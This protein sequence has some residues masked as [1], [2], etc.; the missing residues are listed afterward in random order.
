MLG[1]AAIPALGEPREPEPTASP[2]APSGTTASAEAASPEAATPHAAAAAASDGSINVLVFHGE[3]GEQD[4]PVAEATQAIEDLGAQHGFDVESST[5]PDVFS[6]RNL[7]GYRGVVFLS[8]E[9]TELTSGQEGALQAYLENGGGFLGIRDAARA[10]ERSEWFTGLIGTRPV[11]SLPDPEEIVEVTASGNNPPNEIAE[12]LIDGDVNTKWLTFD[13]TAWIVVRLSEPTVVSQYA[14]ASANDAPGRDPRDWT[15]QGSADG[16]SWTDLDTRAGESFTDRFQTRGFEFENGD[17]YEYYRLD[18][19]ANN[20]DGLTQM[21]EFQ[22]FA[23]DGTEEPEP[24]IEEQQA[25]VSVVDSLHPATDGLPLTWERSDRWINWDPNPTGQVHTVAQVQEHTYD[26]GNGANG[27]FHPISWCRDY[28]GGRSFY[29]GM[30][31]TAESYADEN[32][33]AHLLGAIHWTTGMVRADCQATIGSNYSIERL[34]DTNQP[35]ELD[36]IGEPHGLDIAPDGKVFYIGKAACPSGPIPDWNDPDVGLGCGTIHQWDPETEEATLLLTLDVFGN[37]GSG[38]ELVKTEEGLVGITLDPDFQ[39]NGWLYIYWMPYESIDLETRIG[40]RTVSRLT[41]DFDSASID[42]ETREDLLQW[43]TQIHSCCHAGGGMDFDA[44]GNLYIGTGDANSSQGSSGYSGNNWTQDYLGVSFQD[45]RRTSGNT[46]NLNGKILRITPEADGTYSIPDGNLFTGDEE[47]GGLTQPEIYVMGVRNMSTLSVDPD[48]DWLYAAW[49]GPDA[50]APS[51]ELGPAKYESATVVTE[52]GNEGWPFCVGNRQ[53]YRDRS[54]EDASILTGW[55]DCDNPKNESPRNT[56][57]VDLPPIRD[58]MIWYAPQGGGPVYPERG[59]GSGLPTYVED[60]ATYTQP[61]L[62]GGG[63]AIMSGPAFR[64]SQVD[65]DS[66]VAWPA[67]WEGKWLI[68]DQSNAS[69]RVAVTL[70]EDGIEEQAPPLFAEDLRSIIRSGTGDAALQSWMM[71]AKF[72]PDGALYMID[73]GGGFFSLTNNQKLIRIN[74][75][76]GPATP[77][78]A[79]SATAVQNKPLTI[80]FTGARSGGVSYLWDLGDGSTSSEANP[81][82]T[83]AAAGTYTATLTV[84]YADGETATVSTEVAVECAVPDARDTVWF[85]DSDTGVTNHET[86]GGCTINDLID[87]ESSY[88]NHGG[89]VSHVNDVANQLRKDGVISNRESSQLTRAAA[90]SEI[91]KPGDTG[92]EAIFDGTAESLLGWSQAPSGHFEL[93]DDGTILARGGLG[94]L[95]YSAKEFAD[96]SV[97]MQFRDV[98]PEGVRANSGV[99][100]RFPDPTIPLDERPEGSCGTI[101]SA[102]TSQAWVAIYCGQEIQIYDGETGEPQKTGSVY[103]FDPIGLDDAGVTPKEVWNDYEIRVVGQTYTIIRNGEVIN[104]FDNSPGQESSRAG[105]PPTD[106]RQFSSGF[107]GLQNHGNN[108]LIEFRNIRVQEL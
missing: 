48:T 79:I 98:A 20:G 68:G 94:M 39:D 17:A 67:H 57:L 66:G 43:D 99:F 71:D 32:F 37:R 38:G 95:W 27:A 84:T 26:P 50:P 10:Q 100:V 30:G 65:S 58:D 44:D 33:R 19:T 51:P 7:S 11:G 76:G 75:D 72:G 35:G 88:K 24:E 87:D 9:G 29:T 56:G 78:A 13:P 60:D 92:Y 101:G 108:D 6:T 41:Y 70:D 31:G 47:G 103:N 63:Q 4:D 106:L 55:Y 21:A 96:Y 14:L 81:R 62:R 49:V 2:T 28:E 23:G 83:Y 54:N 59:D 16:E 102:R 15:L 69:N 61:Y 53:P 104:E 73:Y 90:R 86:A 107:I 74:Y 97:K 80:A 8:A 46:N 36:Q 85:R 42:L 5:D 105:D 93:Q 18:I 89:F 1:L 52:A 22:L 64:Q 40:Q 25:T 45:A 34:T 82:H 12:N 91:G 3:P 77:E